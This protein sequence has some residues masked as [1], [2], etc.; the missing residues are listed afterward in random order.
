[1]EPRPRASVGVPA[2]NCLRAACAWITEIGNRFLTQGRHNSVEKPV[3]IGKIDFRH[4]SSVL[5]RNEPRALPFDAARI[6]VGQQ[7]AQSGAGPVHKNANRVRIGPELLGDFRIS[8]L[9]DAVQPE[10]LALTIGEPR[11]R[12]PDLLHKLAE[13]N[14]RGRLDNAPRQERRIFVGDATQSPALAPQSIERSTHSQPAQECRP[15]I[16]ATRAALFERFEKDFLIAVESLVMAF[17]DPEHSAKD[18]RAV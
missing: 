17:Q 6:E 2:G 13:L 4:S 1:L 16:N 10:R 9:F 11:D 14:R 12:V 7:L 3:R 18:N 5:A 8:Q 15:I